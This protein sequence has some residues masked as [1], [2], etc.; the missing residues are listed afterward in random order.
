MYDVDGNILDIS[1]I[2][3]KDPGVMRLKLMTMMLHT[4]YHKMIQGYWVIC[5]IVTTQS[6]ALRF[7]LCVW[8]WPCCGD[9][10]S[11]IAGSP[12]WQESLSHV[13]LSPGHVELGAAGHLHQPGD[14]VGQQV[15]GRLQQWRSSTLRPDV[16]GRNIQVNISLLSNENTTSNVGVRTGDG[17][18]LSQA[19]PLQLAAWPCSALLL[20]SLGT[21]GK[22]LAFQTR[23][24]ACSVTAMVLQCCCSVSSVCSH[25]HPTPLLLGL[26]S[27]VCSQQ[28]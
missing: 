1:S 13:T 6:S 20:S 21:A 2:V 3:R 10:I 28:Q 12:L 19:W 17:C 24:C 25:D 22:Q 4:G 9:D 27:L 15:R 8:L 16:C 23:I 18:C 26:S 7:S 11:N 14:D 5:L